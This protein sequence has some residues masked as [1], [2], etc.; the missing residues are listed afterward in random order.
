MTG[1]G[2]ITILK[3]KDNNEEKNKKKTYFECDECDYCKCA[4]FLITVNKY[5]YIDYF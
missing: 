5:Q 2:K 1:W 4:K 3:Q